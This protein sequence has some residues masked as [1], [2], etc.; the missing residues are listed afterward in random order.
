MEFVGKEFAS[1][2]KFCYAFKDQG[3]PTNIREQKDASEFLSIF[4]DR[5]QDQIKNTSHSEFMVAHFGGLLNN[6]LICKECP[7]QYDREEPFFAI[8]LP[9]LQKK[10][11]FE[12]LSSFIEGEVLD[13]DN[14]YFCEKCQ[15]KVKTVKRVTIKKLPNYLFIALQRLEYNFDLDARVKINDY[16]EFPFE[17]DMEPYTHQFLKKK[18]NLRKS[19]VENFNQETS[20]QME[21]EDCYQYSLKGVVIHMGMAESGHYY[22]IIKQNKIQ[23]QVNSDSIWLEY[24]DTKVSEFNLKKFADVAFGE[25]E[26]Y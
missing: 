9:V 14:A 3:K 5:I 2:R 8:N 26:G 19:T 11:I 12:S 1:P 20:Q 22:S 17:L 24:N 25:K 15:M 6:E 23:E 4:L 16:C 7:H 10:S 18:E 13:G 21:D